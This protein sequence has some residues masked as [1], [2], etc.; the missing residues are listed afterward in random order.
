MPDERIVSIVDD[1]IDTTKIFNDALCGTIDGITVLTFNDPVIAL[2]HFTDN[3]ENYAL[4]I[5]D[6][7]MPNLNGL[8]LLRKIKKLNENVRTILINA[9]EIE[10]DVVF[11][12]Y[13]QL[14][15]IDSY[16]ANS[17]TSNQLCQKVRD[18][19]LVYQLA[20]NLK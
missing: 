12:H 14:G 3:K 11:Q 16:I 20:V 13:L 8:E 17:I 5:S 10:N 6:L 7:R 19:F 1:E 2:Q 4:I 18:E 15:I 9:S